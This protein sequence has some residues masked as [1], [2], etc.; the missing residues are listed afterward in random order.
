MT[1]SYFGQGPPIRFAE[2]EDEGLCTAIRRL[3]NFSDRL[4][5]TAN[6]KGAARTLFLTFLIGVQDLDFQAPWADIKRLHDLLSS[7]PDLRERLNSAQPEEKPN[8][9]TAAV[10][11]AAN[12]NP[13]ALIDQKVLSATKAN[14]VTSAQDM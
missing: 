12:K 7:R 3:H 5:L 1:D 11:S 9:K 8:Y 4:R 10:D 14:L 13:G 2:P 6:T